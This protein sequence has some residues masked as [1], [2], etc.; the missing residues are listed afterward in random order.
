MVTIVTWSLLLHGY[1]VTEEQRLVVVVVVDLVGSS[2]LE[3]VVHRTSVQVADSRLPTVVV[4]LQNRPRVRVDHVLSSN[5]MV[6][7]V[8]LLP[9]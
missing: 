3:L 8:I 5:T 2:I 4:H 6:K 1:L 9:W 7:I